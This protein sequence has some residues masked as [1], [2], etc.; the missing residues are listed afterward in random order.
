M[1][2]EAIDVLILPKDPT[3]REELRRLILDTG[4]RNH[5]PGWTSLLGKPGAARVHG[6]DDKH[7]DNHVPHIHREDGPRE[8]ETRFPESADEI[9]AMAIVYSQDEPDIDEDDLLGRA[10]FRIG[11]M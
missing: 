7:K 11:Y 10:F 8:R 9:D 3:A 5:P 1:S 2:L 6:A 4:R